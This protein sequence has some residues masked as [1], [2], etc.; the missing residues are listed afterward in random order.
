MKSKIY[1]IQTKVFTLTIAVNWTAIRC[2]SLTLFTLAVLAYVLKDMRTIFISLMA[3]VLFIAIGYCCLPSDKPIAKKRYVKKQTLDPPVRR[4]HKEQE[5]V[6][7]NTSDDSDENVEM[8]R[9]TAPGQ[10]QGADALSPSIPQPPTASNTK[11]SSKEDKEM[12][13]YDKVYAELSSLEDLL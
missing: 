12:S 4:R 1:N 9:V 13:E 6:Q 3:A 7:A 5:R 2:V 10:K 11:P 8:N